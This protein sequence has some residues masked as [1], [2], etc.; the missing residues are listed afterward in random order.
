MRSPSLQ[1]LYLQKPLTLIFLI[2]LAVF[3][4]LINDSGVATL[5]QLDRFVAVVASIGFVGY[6]FFFVGRRLSLKEAFVIAM[7]ELCFLASQ[8]YLYYSGV[9][10]FVSL[11]FFAGLIGL[12]RAQEYGFERTPWV[13]Y[14]MLLPC[15]MVKGAVVLW[16]AF[17][18]WGVYLILLRY[19]LRQ[20][21]WCVLLPFVVLLLLLGGYYWAMGAAGVDCYV[22]GMGGPASVWFYPKALLEAVN[23]WWAFLILLPLAGRTDDVR[24]FLGGWLPFRNPKDNS[25]RMVLFSW[26]ALVVIVVCLMIVP[27][28]RTENLMLAYPFLALLLGRLVLFLSEYRRFSIRCFAYC[29]F[30]VGVVMVFLYLVLVGQMMP[31]LHL[32]LL[33]YSCFSQLDLMLGRYTVAPLTAIHWTFFA[34][35][36]FA[37]GTLLYQLFHR[38]NVKILF[39]TLACYLAFYMLLNWTILHAPVL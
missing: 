12:Y 1:Y 11:L 8:Q 17:L 9:D 14:A 34:V 36:F 21:L 30:S 19:T 38:V 15:A 39:A 5:M 25:E 6:F 28:K 35:F 37:L 20:V 22:L 26:I 31:D 3:S 33:D 18:I 23:L 13:A 2:A 10:A 7:L 4:P 29:S 32:S 16:V 27:E 24:K